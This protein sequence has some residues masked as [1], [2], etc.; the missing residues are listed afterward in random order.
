YNGF[1]HAVGMAPETAS[2]RPARRRAPMKPAKAY[3]CIVQYTPDPARGEAANVGVLLFAPEH[4]FLDAKLSSSNDRVRRFFGPDVELDL[5]R[6][7]AMK[8]SLRRRLRAEAGRFR[9]ADDLRHFVQTRA[10]QII[11]TPPRP[12][13]VVDPGKDLEVLFQE[14]VGERS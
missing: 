6:V 9:T 13:T 11:L 3:Y 5:G 4:G 7:R 8:Q 10:N 12:M 2:V 14:L 1:T